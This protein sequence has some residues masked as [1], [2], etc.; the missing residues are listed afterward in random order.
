MKIG[1]FEEE[2]QHQ[3]SLYKTL[4]MLVT[5]TE[6]ADSRLIQRGTFPTLF[7]K[8]FEFREKECNI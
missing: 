3:D 7:L 6:D 5:G 2:I 4:N 1:Q 8:R